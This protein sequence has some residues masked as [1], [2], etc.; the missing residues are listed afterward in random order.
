LNKKIFKQVKKNFIWINVTD[1]GIIFLTLPLAILIYL[2][3]KHL[4]MEQ[5]RDRR[6][7]GNSGNEYREKNRG[8]EHRED[9]DRQSSYGGE[10]EDENDYEMQNPGSNYN[11]GRSGRNM[12]NQNAGNYGERYGEYSGGSMRNRNEDREYGS[13][14]SVGMGSSGSQGSQRS[15]GNWDN[16]Y[17]GGW[18]SQGEGNW[19]N[20]RENWRAQNENDWRNQVE[21]NRGGYQGFG[22]SGMGTGKWEPDYT[23]GSMYGRQTSGGGGFRGKGPKD[24]KRS[25]ERI[26]EDISDRL[27]DDDDIDAS[28][29]N[30]S[31]K[32]CEVTLSGAVDNK[33]AKRRAEDIAESV[34]GVREVQNQIH[35]SKQS[36]Q[37]GGYTGTGSEYSSTTAKGTSSPLGKEE[38]SPAK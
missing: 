7:S 37:Q 13:Y 10:F 6:Y 32:D 1:N 16:Q 15:G 26:K 11:R 34:S 4:F 20:Q 5:Q 3:S 28:E 22:S 36:F 27:T 18:G 14:G 2:I 12:E 17:E 30:V 25:D 31:V 23:G 8:K 19:R 21:R 33:D 38:K 29:I 9:Y 35:V 24:Y